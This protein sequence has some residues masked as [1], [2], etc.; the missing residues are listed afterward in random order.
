MNILKK[1]KSWF[2][3]PSDTTQQEA[4]NIKND[5]N[6][7]TFSIDGFGKHWI[8]V[9]LVNT[10]EYSCQAFA[11]LLFGLNEGQYQ[12]SILNIL[13]SLSKEHPVLTPAVEKIL[14]DWE[15]LLSQNTENSDDSS[16]V[17]NYKS[18]PFIRPRNVFLGGN[19]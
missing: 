11:K 16:V 14:V 10:D 3:K 8:Y 7:I 4:K 15:I 13:A 12:N 9:E 19:K 17:A 18:R 1:I 5:S 2:A 6:S